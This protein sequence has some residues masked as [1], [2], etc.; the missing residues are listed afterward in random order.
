MPTLS[1][2]DPVLETQV[3]W[4]RYKNVIFAV[5]VLALLTVTAWGGYR[6]Y[7]L[8]RAET[9]AALLATAKTAA[10][11]QKVIAQ[12][13]ATPAGASAYLFLAEEQRK[14]KK[15]GEAN[16]TLQ[17]FIDKYPKH[18][19]KG[20]ARM[21]LAANLESLGKPDEAL[22]VYQRLATDDPQGFTA[23]IALLAQVHIFKDKSQI[24]EARRVCEAIMTQYRE[25]LVANEATRQLRLLKGNEPEPPPQSTQPA[26]LRPASGG[27]P[28]PVAS[29]A[30]PP[31][32]PP[33]AAPAAPPAA[34]P[35]VRDTPQATA[36]PK[37]RR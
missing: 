20:T 21:A 32:A 26:Q 10:D 3:F 31:A 9:A 6:F 33:T 13:E 12:Y 30:A 18:Q 15:F 24:A 19:L 35:P 14:E 8:R 11:F 16:A 27:T 1:S 36:S 17:S 28:M 2:T 7:S 23:P 34:A 5:L 25:S 29:A 22:I 4:E 37:R